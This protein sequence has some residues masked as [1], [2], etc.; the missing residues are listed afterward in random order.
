V[1]GVS[2]HDNGIASV[3]KS[4]GINV[5]LEVGA[6]Q[7][8]AGIVAHNDRVTHV[9]DLQRGRTKRTALSQR[10]LLEPL[11]RRDAVIF[12]KAW[13]FGSNRRCIELDLF[14][15][16]LGLYLNKATFDRLL[17]RIGQIA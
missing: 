2:A 1:S 13:R 4:V 5:E 6:I 15:I 7:S 3:D 8:C 11:Q 16:F 17:H 10:C 9:D 12:L 14:R